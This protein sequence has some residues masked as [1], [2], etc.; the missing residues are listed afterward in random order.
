MYIFPYDQIH[1]KFYGHSNYRSDMTYN[2][3][4]FTFKV[5]NKCTGGL[6]DFTLVSSSY[7]F[8]STFVLLFPGHFLTSS[9]S[10]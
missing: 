5:N 7:S 9:D 3:R 1:V 6:H 4:Y 8:T 2:S 10:E